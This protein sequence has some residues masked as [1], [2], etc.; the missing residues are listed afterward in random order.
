VLEWLF[1]L[2]A[3][4]AIDLRLPR[5]VRYHASAISADCRRLIESDLGLPVVSTYGAV[6]TF[7]IGFECEERDGFHLHDD[8]C[9]VRVV[10]EDGTDAASD[11]LGEVVVSNLVNRAMVLLNYRLGD[12]AALAPAGCACGRTFP[13]LTALQGRVSEI[14]HLPSGRPVHPGTLAN[15][16]YVSGLLR[17]Q[18]IQ[19]TQDRFRL[20]VVTAD[21]AAYE[22]VVRAALPDLRSLLEGAAVEVVRRDAI[23]DTERRK[24]R[25]V[26]ALPADRRR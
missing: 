7:G 21:D 23:E 20:E 12:L 25:R 2:A 22:R 10:A 4:G 18:L 19:E 1:R 9:H 14:V 24:L 17:F 13:L 6:E 8:L 5:L 26:V 3:A 11:E 15:V 16:L